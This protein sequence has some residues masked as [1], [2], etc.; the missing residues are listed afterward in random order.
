MVLI[1]HV[2]DLA[3]GLM[4]IWNVGHIRA[5]NENDFRPILI[6]RCYFIISDRALMH[7]Y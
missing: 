7:Y 2:V 5:I 6:L 1:E 3:H 4:L